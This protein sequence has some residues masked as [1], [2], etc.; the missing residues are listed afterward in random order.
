MLPLLGLAVSLQPALRPPPL[1]R[2]PP[3]L[4][5]PPLLRLGTGDAAAETATTGAAADTS[6]GAGGGGA[7]VA[8][9]GAASSAAASAVAPS[10]AP[11]PQQA[12]AAS[13]SAA[14][15]TPSPW[16]ILRGVLQCDSWHEFTV[17]MREEYGDVLKVDLWP[18]LPPIYFLMGKAANRAVLSDLDASLQQILQELINVLPVS[19]RIPKEEDVQL[20]KKVATLFQSGAVIDSLLPSFRTTARGVRERWMRRPAPS[21]PLLVFFELSEFVLR[22]D[23]ELLYGRRFSETHAPLLLPRFTQWVENIANGQLV[24]FF[25]ELGRCL[26]EEM[27]ISVLEL[28]AEERPLRQVPPRRDRGAAGAPAALR[29]RAVGDAHLPAGG[30]ARKEQRG[31]RGRAA[32]DDPHGGGLQHAGRLL[33]ALSVRTMISWRRSPTRRSLTN[34]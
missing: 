32:D 7:C 10:G 14:A 30:R 33:L 29:G 3:P 26:R 17:Q 34:H 24:G 23:L 31:G 1:L 19:A 13:A 11:P 16:S 22:A 2:P 9:T 18:V 15:G 12:A 8:S 21:R 28:P 25:D 20:Q 5:P 4:R 6:A 27:A